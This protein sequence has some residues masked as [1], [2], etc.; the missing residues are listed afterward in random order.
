MLKRFSQILPRSKRIHYVGSILQKLSPV[1]APIVVRD[2]NDE[3]L[4]GFRSAFPAAHENEIRRLLDRYKLFGFRFWLIQEHLASLSTTNLRRYVREQCAVRGGEHLEEAIKSNRPLI[5]FTP[6]YGNFILAGI[7]LAL[8]LENQ[9]RLLFF[10]NPPGRNAI[11]SE[12][13]TLIRT[14]DT[15]A[16][17]EHNNR[18]GL[19]RVMKDLNGDSAL[20]LMPDI[21]EV[22]PGVRYVPFFGRFAL[23]MTGA[24]HLA[25]RS[26]ALILPMC[27]DMS[28]NGPFTLDIFPPLILTQSGDRNRDL[29]ENVSH[30]AN[31]TEGI[32]RRDASHWTMWPSFVARTVATPSLPTDGESWMALPH[33]IRGALSGLIPDLARVLDFPEREWHDA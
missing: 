25:L 2:H 19:K 32:I 10:Y 6:H 22:N 26:D 15:G 14:L 18:A 31:A 11:A 30:L 23:M 24:I 21:F 5:F 8:E 16:I 33:S 27:V 28:K 29:Y 13:D 3:V 17:A 7:K 4:G 1:I 20:F 12:M 9:R